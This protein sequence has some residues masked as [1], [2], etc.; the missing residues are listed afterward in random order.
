MPAENGE[1]VA[2]LSEAR[3]PRDQAR[4]KAAQPLPC[5]GQRFVVPIEPQNLSVGTTAK[6]NLLAMSSPSQRAVEI[7]FARSR[8][9]QFDHFP[10]E[11]GD[12]RKH[13]SVTGAV[14]LPIV[15]EAFDGVF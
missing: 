5:H 10:Y 6:Q 8:T 7:P 15:V 12:M 13:R 2:C 11:H 3:P 9:E 1:N 4:P 14:T